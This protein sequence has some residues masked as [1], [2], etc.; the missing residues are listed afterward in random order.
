MKAGF[1]KT[2]ITPRLGGELSGFGPF[3]CRTSTG[4]REKLWARAAAFDCGG[5]RM[6]IVSCD[7][8]GLIAPITE[9]VRK[10]VA[11]PAGIPEEALGIF[12]SHT[13]SGPNPTAYH[14]W[15]EMDPAY[16]E[17][18]PIKIGQACVRACQNLQAVQVAY[19]EAA[20]AGIGINREYE[21]KKWPPA[22]VLSDDWRPE[23][24][25]LTD[26]TCHVLTFRNQSGRMLGFISSFGCHPVVCCE[27][28]RLIHG[29]FCGIATNQLESE[30]PGA[31]GLFIQGAHGDVNT[32]VAHQPEAESYSALE[33][34]AARYARAVRAGMGE[35]E[36]VAVANMAFCSL[37]KTFSR[38]N[39]SIE[40]LEGMLTQCTRQ[41]RLEA[42]EEEL[43]GQAARRNIVMAITLRNL[44]DQARSDRPLVTPA[45]IYGF[46]LGP[47]AFLG[48]GFETYQTIKNE[49]K[50]QAAHQPL[51][52]ASLA[53]DGLGYAVDRQ[54]AARGGYAAEFAPFIL[55][56]LP[57]ADIH[58]E[59]V[60]ALLEADRK[61]AGSGE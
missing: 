42:G 28:T 22:Q 20:C 26:T 35:A 24:P 5:T 41:F 38:K 55:G 30:Q 19:R 10:L 45:E 1:A 49:V 39:F 47:V 36:P 48:S 13:H 6:I 33:V 9:K 25:E 14:G 44:L 53:N 56:T 3:I 58:P 40:Q 32:G 23:K 34:I 15:G 31:V 11:A 52:I 57:Y 50:T 60:A 54:C 51:I 21:K 37:K 61:L 59:L 12:S 29:D 18:L 17:V 7:L 2:D 8:I 43:T 16:A 4:V 27:D 46:R